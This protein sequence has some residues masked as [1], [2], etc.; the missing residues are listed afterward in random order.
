MRL[1]HRRDAPPA[2][3]LARLP[4]DERVVAWAD[5]ASG[6]VVVATPTGLWWPDPDGHRLIGWQ[7][8]DKAT[9]RERLLVVVE[10]EVVEDILLVD[11]DPVAAEL[12]V[13]R[14][15]P[16]TIRKR[17]EANVVRSEIGAV[18]GG[19]ARFVARRIPG[20]DGLA[21]WARLEPGTPDSEP[22]RSAVAARLA[23]MRADWAA[24][25]ADL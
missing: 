1:F 15:L 20:T 16:P 4:K 18:S 23:R 2:D 19:A 8:I 13:P 14:D 5:T 17:V 21:W 10:A 6:D 25:Q 22:V 11:R 24:E 12:A 9:W 7:Y 3:V